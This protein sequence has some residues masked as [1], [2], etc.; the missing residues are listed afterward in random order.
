[1]TQ[2]LYLKLKLEFRLFPFTGEMTQRLDL[3][4]QRAA[5]FVLKTLLTNLSKS[6]LQLSMLWV[7]S[8]LS[9]RT[10]HMAS[11]ISP[12]G[13]FTRPSNGDFLIQSSNSASSILSSA[14]LLSI[15]LQ[16]FAKSPLT[17]SVILVTHNFNAPTSFV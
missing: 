9:F 4:I 1:M 6:F 7:S 13:V 2:R 5:G 11:I 15:F 17:S 10:S 16:A 12:S 14:G 8:P 3:I